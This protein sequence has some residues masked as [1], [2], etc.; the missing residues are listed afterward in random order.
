MRTIIRG[1]HAFMLPQPLYTK[2]L[3]PSGAG[4]RSIADRYQ[5]EALSTFLI[6]LVRKDRDFIAKQ[7]VGNG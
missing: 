7:D 3:Q 6:A 2:A 5:T 4:A 1:K